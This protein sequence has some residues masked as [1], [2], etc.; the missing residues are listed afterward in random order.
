MIESTTE[1]QALPAYVTRRMQERPTDDAGQ[2]S[3]HVGLRQDLPWEKRKV[4][5]TRSGAQKTA[6]V[7]EEET[8][9]ALQSASAA[10]LGLDLEEQKRLVD[11]YERTIQSIKEGEIVK[12]R[13]LSVSKDE[14]IVD[15]GF[16]SEGVIPR[17]EFPMEGIAPGDPV[18]VFLE[19]VEDQNGQLVLSKQKADF[20]RVW[21]RIKEAHE[22]RHLVRGRL[23]RRIK[24]GVVVDLF[25]AEAFLPGSQIALRQVSD[26]DNLLGT[27]MEFKIIKLNKN[28]RNIVVSRRV[29]LEEERNKLRDRLLE[30][31]EVGQVREGIV[32]N[33]TDF[34]VFVDLGGVDGLLHITD[35][36]WGRIVHPNEIT[37]VGETIHVKV[38]D[39]N[40]ETTRISLGLKQ[41][42]PY[43][44]ENIEARYPLGSRVKGRIVSVTDYGAFIE[45]EKGIE[46]LIHVSE[47]SWTQ[48]VKHPSKLVKP[49]D[50]I[51]AVVLNIDKENEKISLGIKQ[52]E[53]DPW[54]VVDINFPVGNEVEG[55]VRN[56]TAFGAFVELDEG[57]DGLVH[58]SDMSWTKRLQ[59]PNE[60]VKKGDSL[61]VKILSIDKENRRISLGIK[62]L[63]EDPWPTF[64]M[65]YPVGSDRDKVP[66]T[67][68][69]DR[70]LVVEIDPGVEAFVPIQFLGVPDLK[71]PDE[72]FK[73]GDS[74][75]VRLIEV[76]K[77]ARKIVASVTDYMKARE[78]SELSQYLAAHPVSTVK[79]ADAADAKKKRRKK[80]DETDGEGT[81][82]AVSGEPDSDI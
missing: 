27:E 9:L 17:S 16:K 41:L 68:L 24:G 31:I 70:G 42:E 56:L 20:M 79:L 1:T 11:H 45:L 65:I 62:Q 73:D 64:P 46:G 72:A 12:G 81:D 39:Y 19:A 3:R 34:G 61:K 78:A 50:E 2:R 55:K 7:S 82:A 47:M 60:M 10:D 8:A 66:V 40:P 15:V 52:L 32:K 37:K 5:G 28:R 51:E 33:V 53:P 21:D 35:M 48:H 22:E 14:V 29:V 54:S 36:S 75:P 58:I 74:L 43:P 63:V 76:D 49:G 38:L 57:I 69:L 26:F 23:V 6:R 4:K 44:W 25:G 13:I 71:K 59:H 80:G 18:E 67:R 30:E 77:T